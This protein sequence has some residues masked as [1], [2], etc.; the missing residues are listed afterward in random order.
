MTLMYVGRHGQ[1]IDNLNRILN[2]HR[3][4]PL[5]ELGEQQADQLAGGMA[6][7][8]IRIDWVYTSPLCRAHR[9]AQIV[10]E[11]L[12]LHEPIV[13]PALIERHF[14]MLTGCSIDIIPKLVPATH[15]LK[16]ETVTYFLEAPE[17]E[18]YPTAFRRAKE[19][20]ERL[21]EKHPDET[22]LLICHTDIGKML[23]AAHYG[24]H[25]REALRRFHF[26][27]CELLELMPNGEPG[28]H[29]IRMEQH[30]C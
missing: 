5:T 19:L 29:I 14:G 15:I 8:G 11:T 7:L 26:G 25:W 18:R 23:Y 30:N 27:N 6:A 16:T 24:L 9:T 2:G 3:D 28:E 20:L 17:S 4:G 10:C 13:E 21:Q 1:N 12:D 22:L